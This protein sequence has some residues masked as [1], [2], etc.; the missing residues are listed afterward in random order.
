MQNN[1][2]KRNG[3]DYFSFILLFTSC[4]TILRS[5]GSIAESCKSSSSSS[6]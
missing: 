4:G 3:H 2:K 6:L 5:Q 1:N